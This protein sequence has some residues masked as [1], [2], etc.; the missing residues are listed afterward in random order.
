MLLRTLLLRSTNIKYQFAAKKTVKYALWRAYALLTVERASNLYYSP[1]EEIKYGQRFERRFSSRDRLVF[2]L[3]VD[4]VKN[5]IP[6]EEHFVRRSLFQ[7]YTRNTGWDETPLYTEALKEISNNCFRGKYKTPE[8]LKIRSQ[9][10]DKLF[11]DIKNSGFKSTLDLFRTGWLDDPSKL[12]DEVSVI[13]SRNGD[14]I[15]NDGWH[16]FCIAK[17][18]ESEKIPVR[19][20]INH[21]SCK[22]IPDSLKNGNK[23]YNK[24]I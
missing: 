12:M 6:I 22:H 1:T 7:R 3:S 20:L 2:Y 23:Y 17:I 18:F 13:P 10:C 9:G 21:T 19:L 16:R 5:I 24:M 8:D 15:L 14:L 11:D 4:R